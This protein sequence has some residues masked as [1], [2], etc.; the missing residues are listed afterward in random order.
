[1]PFYFY[2]MESFGFLVQLSELVTGLF[3]GDL[4]T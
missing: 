1:M 4:V 2:Y 3:F